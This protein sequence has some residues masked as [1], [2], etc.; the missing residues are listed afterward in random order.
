ME[1]SS[2]NLILAS[3]SKYR[4][5]L[6]QRLATPFSCQS[7]EIDESA[8]PGESPDELVERLAFQKARCIAT[9]ERNAIVIGSDQVAV[10]NQRI[11]GKPGS[12]QE[13]VTQLA[14]FS[15]QVVK[16]LTAVSVQ[17][18]A[19]NF[20]DHHTDHTSVYFRLLSG[21]EIEHY[22]QR[23]QPYDCAGSFK[24]E[25]QGIVLFDRINS[26]DPTALIGLPL[27]RTAHML[28]SAGMMLP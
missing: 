3:T 2:A 26:N 11:I 15:G 16:F 24:S 5:L 17:C 23:E 9:R 14:S 4:K 27:I 1:S 28:R 22:L 18:V 19:N 7:P 6:L 12:H 25:A 10:H 13:A 8:V 21:V 20:S